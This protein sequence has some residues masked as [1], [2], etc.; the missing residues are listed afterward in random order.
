[1]HNKRHIMGILQPQM[2]T[3]LSTVQVQRSFDRSK[4][5]FPDISARTE[6]IFTIGSYLV[7]WSEALDSAGEQS[8]HLPLQRP[9]AILQK[10]PYLQTPIW[11]N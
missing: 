11:T 6:G 4:H 3:L 10:P 2:H 8:M 1:M 9:G 7:H 5:K